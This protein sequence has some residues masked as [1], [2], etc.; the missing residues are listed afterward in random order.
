MSSRLKRPGKGSH[1]KVR[2]PRRTRVR[3]R[4]ESEVRNW[5]T[6][7]ETSTSRSAAGSPSTA[8]GHRSGDGAKRARLGG[9]HPRRALSAGVG[10]VDLAAQR[11]KPKRRQSQEAIDEEVEQVDE[12]VLVEDEETKR[13]KRG[14]RLAGRQ[15]HPQKAVAAHG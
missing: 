7:P 8:G 12:N 1:S 4:G 9:G 15:A 3:T 2:R 14:G 13:A 5:P 10:A 6:G 11:P